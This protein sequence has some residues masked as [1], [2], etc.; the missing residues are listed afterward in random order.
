MQH[1]SM[2]SWKGS[3]SGTLPTSDRHYPWLVHSRIE[4]V[5]LRE[6]GGRFRYFVTDLN[7]WRL[8]LPG[9]VRHFEVHVHWLGLH[10]VLR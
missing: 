7:E 2:L 4:T 3:A 6:G 5:R 9:V 8:A 10:T 1:L